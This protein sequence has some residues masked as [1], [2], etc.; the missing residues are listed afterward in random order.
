[1]ELNIKKVNN[2]ISKWIED[3]NRH[4][5]KEDIQLVQ[6]HMKRC[7]APLIMREMQIKTKLRY[8]L[9]QVRKA[10]IKESINNKF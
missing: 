8:H 5:S 9:T 7:S 10:I 3:L 2:T 4:L 1:M 6:R